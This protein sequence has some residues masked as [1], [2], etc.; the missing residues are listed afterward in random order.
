[1]E[2]A[3]SAGPLPHIVVNGGT[4]GIQKFA[5]DLAD[6]NIDTIVTDC[7]TYAA[8]DLRA[9]WSDPTARAQALQL[10]SQPVIGTQTG[11][12]WG[13]DSTSQGIF[14]N[15]AEADSAYACP[16]PPTFTP[17]QAAL[18]I[19][20][21]VDRHDGTPAHSADTE[22]NY[23]YLSCADE[24]DDPG[25]NAMVD[26]LAGHVPA[27]STVGTSL[28]AA[29]WATLAAVAGQSLVF[30]DPSILGLSDNGGYFVATPQ[31]GGPIL[32]FASVIGGYYPL[33]AVY[34]G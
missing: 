27:G 28:S 13:G 5:D 23:P 3:V 15:W 31:V 26:G 32:V 24:T 25:C 30:D 18:T 6:G 4:P 12:D 17:A 21:L 16:A 10:L 7:W 34:Q 1:V 22:A 14:F 2:T 33:I 29:Q 9:R 19:Q 11:Y 8:S 20:R